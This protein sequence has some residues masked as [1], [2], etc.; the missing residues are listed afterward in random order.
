MDSVDDRKRAL[1]AHV[2]G[3]CRRPGPA[4]EA[5]STAA[6]RLLL[7]SGLLSGAR[8]I[9]LYRALPSELQTAGLAQA[10]EQAG[11]RVVYPVVQDAERV[12]A[13]APPE[14]PL[15]K[16]A[17]GIEEPAVDASR[18]PLSALDLL[19]VPGL[20]GDSGGRRLGRGRGHYDATLR[21]AP[22]ALAVLLIFDAGLV[23]EVPVGDHDAQVDAVC[24]ESRLLLCS[25]R[26]R[27]RASGGGEP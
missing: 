13:F 14:G 1:R 12:L 27:Q 4:V 26:A 17:L 8:T 21:A 9:A 25:G 2:K 23:P 7:A 10:L 5:A 20:A 24:T 18:V 22:Q 15:R 19:V 6:Q 16:G 3:A 11:A